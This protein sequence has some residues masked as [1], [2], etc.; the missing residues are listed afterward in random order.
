MPNTDTSAG[1]MYSSLRLK[2][3][4]SQEIHSD[5]VAKRDTVKFFF[6]GLVTHK[7]RGTKQTKLTKD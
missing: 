4:R 1:E 2:V 3:I 5:L 6:H 7:L